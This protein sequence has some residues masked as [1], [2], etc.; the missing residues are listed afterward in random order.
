MVYYKKRMAI[1][2][3]NILMLGFIIMFYSCGSPEENVKQKKHDEVKGNTDYDSLKTDCLFVEKDTH[4]QTEKKVKKD[5]FTFNQLVNTYDQSLSIINKKPDS[6]LHLD[7]RSVLR[8]I[9]T[10]EYTFIN[11]GN[12]KYMKTLNILC[13]NSDG[14]VAG[15]FHTVFYKLI[16]KHFSKVFEYFFKAKYKCLEKCLIRSLRI[17]IEINGN[18]N[19]RKEEIYDIINEQIDRDKLSGERRRYLDSLLNEIEKPAA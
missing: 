13:E 10:L 7:D 16:N 8:L 6:V 14:Y 3:L 11:T 12:E 1:F 5:T 15:H 19:K 18:S 9:D 17:N 2:F 4:D